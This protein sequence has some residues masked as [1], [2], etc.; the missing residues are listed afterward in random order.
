VRTKPRLMRELF[1]TGNHTAAWDADKIPKHAWMDLYADLYRQC[2]GETTAPE[3]I[4]ENAK[5]RM[6]TLRA[7]GLIK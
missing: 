5:N 3:A 7:N 4:L 2:F 1:Q 6:Q